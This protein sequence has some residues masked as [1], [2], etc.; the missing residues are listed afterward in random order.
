MADVCYLRHI[1]LAEV[2]EVMFPHQV[3]RCSL[4][5]QKP[6]AQRSSAGAAVLLPWRIATIMHISIGHMT[7]QFCPM[8]LTSKSPAGATNTPANLPDTAEIV[9]V[10]PC[11]IKKIMI[12]RERI[13]KT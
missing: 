6:P 2:P 1:G 7:G 13:N 9:E 10:L 5:K 4:Q 11:A 3:S 12:L 8:S